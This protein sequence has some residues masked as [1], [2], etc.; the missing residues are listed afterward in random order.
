MQLAHTLKKVMCPCVFLVLFLSFFL[1]G[2]LLIG[3]TCHHSAHQ[4]GSVKAGGDMELALSQSNGTAAGARRTDC[5]AASG[6]S[7]ENQL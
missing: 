5:F 2:S 7:V 6:P 3:H 1:S 4:A